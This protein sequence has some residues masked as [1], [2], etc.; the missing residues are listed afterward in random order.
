MARQIK[1][2]NGLRVAT[3]CESREQFVAKFHRLS[4]SCAV[5]IPS[6][7]RTVGTDTAFAFTLADGSVALAGTGTV[8]DQFTSNDNRFGRP[9]VVVGIVQLQR[10]TE[11][12]FE[13]MLI[14]QALHAA[15]QP[16]APPKPASAELPP[17]RRTPP[18]M[19][20]V[21]PDLPGMPPQRDTPTPW[22]RDQRLTGAIELF[23]ARDVSPDLAATVAKAVAHPSRRLPPLDDLGGSSSIVTASAPAMSMPEAPALPRAIA[24]AMSLPNAP[25]M[26]MPPA[27][28]LPRPSAPM[29]P[30]PF[31]SL[32]PLPERPRSRGMWLGVAVMLVAGLAA[33]IIVGRLKTDES[34]AATP[35]ASAAPATADAAL[36]AEA[37]PPDAGAP[38][39]ADSEQ[40]A[41]AD[42][43]A[44]DAVSSA[45][46]SNAKPA[47]APVTPKRATR[48]TT[49]KSTK[50]TAHTVKRTATKSTT[51][52]K[53]TRA[54][55][56][57][58]HRKSHKACTSLDCL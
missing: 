10:D 39:D 20:A 46:A 40:A 44:A 12:V 51:S 13:D 56:T 6:A 48:T 32:P 49:K 35:A 29:M 34:A 19:Q 14:E 21:R 22:I 8:L 1:H 24:P 54:H 43:H 31:A 27:P 4:E 52:R 9:G 15:G 28:A 53:T 2:A 30:N 38:A 47:V 50:K 36:A 45:D 25:A 26:S 58:K 11:R 23:D 7:H 55:T 33:G 41:A 42:E 18:P 57:R 17:M 16:A 37:P 3:R 5:F